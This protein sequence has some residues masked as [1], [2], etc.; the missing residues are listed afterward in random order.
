[1]KNNRRVFLQGAGSVGALAVMALPL[2]TIPSLLVD[3]RKP[4]VHFPGD[5]R[6]RIAVASYPFREFI[7]GAHE[8]HAVSSKMPIRE[9][10]AHVKQKFNVTHIEP[11]SEHFLSLEPEY[12]EEIRSA[13]HGAGCAIANIAADGE[14]SIYA[15]NAEARSKALAFGKNWIDAAARLGSPSVRLNI[16]EA[17][18]D[19]PD[20]ALAVES[21]QQIA[22]HAKKKNIVVHHENDNP[23]SESPAF[24]VEVLDK[25][26]SPWVRSLPDF[27]NSF[28]ALPAEEAFKALDHLFA[29]AYGISHAKD[30]ITNPKGV[31]VPVDMKRIFAIAA[32]HNYKGYFSMEWDTE[33]D[34]YAGTEKLIRA[35]LAALA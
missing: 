16:A 23:V 7:L 19:Q 20:V 34:P 4:S 2:N 26:K 11:W 24:L 33:G 3:E 22:E 29:R 30:P 5:A 8:P 15:K 13:V 27:G 10:A 21:L 1:M 12:L 9:F 17:K 35:T 18:G 31:V 6:G 25:V 28:A 32:K 14:N